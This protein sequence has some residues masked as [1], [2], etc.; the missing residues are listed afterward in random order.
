MKINLKKKYKN[1]TNKKK[2]DLC[3]ESP[4]LSKNLSKFAF[5]FLNKKEETNPRKFLHKI[6]SFKRRQA[7]TE[8]DSKKRDDQREGRGKKIKNHCK[9]A[10][11]NKNHSF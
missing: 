4:D 6:T 9:N 5:F 11:K 2:L 7:K 10:M 3:S 8:R 1:P